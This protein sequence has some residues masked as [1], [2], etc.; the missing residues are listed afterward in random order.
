M[1]GRPQ[2]HLLR[3]YE[4]S[5]DKLRAAVQADPAV[6]AEVEAE[7]SLCQLIPDERCHMTRDY[8]KT[9]EEALS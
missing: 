5:P 2:Y 9:L 6:R 1:T 4:R 7:V 8:K 3:R